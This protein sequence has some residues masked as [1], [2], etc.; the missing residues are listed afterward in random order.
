MEEKLANSTFDC[1]QLE[2]GKKRKRERGERKREKKIE[3]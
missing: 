2:G 3:L 1:F